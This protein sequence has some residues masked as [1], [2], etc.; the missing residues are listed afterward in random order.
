MRPSV[1]AR[2]SRRA[3]DGGGGRRWPLW[4]TF[5]AHWLDTHPSDLVGLVRQL[6]HSSLDTTRIY[7]QPTADEIA[8]RL[9]RL[10]LNVYGG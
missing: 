7:T 10:T 1:P 4:H 8:E 6:G 3:H 2:R 9:E 5:A